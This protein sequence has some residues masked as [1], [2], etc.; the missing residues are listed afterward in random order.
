[1]HVSI[2]KDGKTLKERWPE[3]TPVHAAIM[4]HA[5]CGGMI[6]RGS[7]HHNAVKYFNELTGKSLSEAGNYTEGFMT[8]HSRFVDREEAGD[9]IKAQGGELRYDDK[10]LYS[11]DLY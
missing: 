6:I 2:R 7:R 5:W 4:F 3:E 9:M 10:E 1:M 11:E 8:N